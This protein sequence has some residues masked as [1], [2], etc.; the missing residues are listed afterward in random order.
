MFLSGL[1][2]LIAAASTVQAQDRPRGGGFQFGFGGPGG[3]GG[4]SFDANLLAT[5]EVQKELGVSDE[6]KGLIEDMLT[7]IRN[8]MRAA[9]GQGGAGGFQN[10]QNLSEEE[11]N[12]L[13]AEGQKRMEEMNKKTEEMITMVLEPK[14]TDRFGQLRLQ[15]AGVGAF[16]RPDIAEKIGLSQEQK[17]KMKKIQDDARPDP[18]AFA[19][20]QNMSEEERREAFTK[21]REK[22]EKAN[23]DILNVLTAEQKETWAKLQG[24]KFDFPPP[25][26]GRRPGGGQ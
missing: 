11:R 16:N 7:D 8:Q 24:K 25:Q 26:F 18:S 1:A 14:Q 3:F 9:R 5:P 2:L 20:F 10:F 4:A 13:I 22:G 21:M 6:Q 15:R 19:S 12:K 23:A 17:D